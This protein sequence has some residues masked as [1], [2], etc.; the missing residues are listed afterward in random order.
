[1]DNTISFFFKWAGDGHPLIDI[2]H[3]RDWGECSSWTDFS[4]AS[5]GKYDFSKHPCN[6][7]TWGKQKPSTLSL[8]TLVVIEMLNALNALS[9]EGSLL[10]VG[11]FCNPWLIAAITGSILLH[12]MILYVPLFERIFNTVPLTLN[13]WAL[14]MAC[15]FP[16]VLLDEILKFFSR[17]RTQA[18]LK[19][20]LEAQH[21]HAKAE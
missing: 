7:F 13:D 1:M 11:I 8:T 16:V 15:A 9:D 21:H 3:L 2:K 19:K 17:K 5:F 18:D 10:T 4:V 12:C 6:Y 14:V 20:R